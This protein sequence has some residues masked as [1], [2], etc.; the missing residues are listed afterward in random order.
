[1]L[2]MAIVMME[3]LILSIVFATAERT[4]PIVTKEQHWNVNRGVLQVVLLRVVLLVQGGAL[5][6]LLV[7][8]QVPV[9]QAARF[10]VPFLTMMVIPIKQL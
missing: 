2:S 3:A 9:P 1:M 10:T 8:H 6:H 4:V 7:D 5:H